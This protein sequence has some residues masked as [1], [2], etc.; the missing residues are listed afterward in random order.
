MVRDIHSTLY[1]C[2]VMHHRFTPRVHHFSYR[3]FYLWLNLDELDTLSEHLPCFS[4]NRFNLFSF[5]DLDHLDLGAG[6]TKANL[7]KWLENQGMETGPI[8]RVM[9]LA[10]P[11]VLGHIFNPVSFFY[12]F[13]EGDVPLCVV[14]QVTNTFREQKPYLL[15]ERDS[16]GAFARVTPKYFYVSPFAELGQS[17]DF[18]LALPGEKLQIQIDNREG[19]QR[20]L[21]ST[22][23]G[24][25]RPLTHGRLL[26][27]AFKYPLLTMR[28]IF[29]IHWHALLLWMRHVP[30]HRKAANPGFQK[31]LFKPHHSIAS[32]RVP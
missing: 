18:K 28:V 29:L 30:F 22:L 4:R 23:T 5:Y 12:C 13:G 7:L 20:N 24:V 9:L 31:D 10:F 32:S 1:E 14:A 6:S 8:R 15:C 19:D 3:V 16:T 17:F 21:A 27:F 2:N 26:W 25:R 11:R